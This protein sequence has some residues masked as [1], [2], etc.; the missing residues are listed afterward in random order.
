MLN[1]V[2]MSVIMLNVVMLN[3]VRL[4]VVAHLMQVS[5]AS[6]QYMHVQFNSLNQIIVDVSF[7]LACFVRK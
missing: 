3:V 5:N 7:K 1:V 2:L 6:A 4:S